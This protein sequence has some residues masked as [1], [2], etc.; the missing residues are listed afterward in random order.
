VSR[1]D[2]A[3]LSVYVS[4]SPSGYR[5]DIDGLRAI[6]VVAVLAFHAS[7]A[8]FPGGFAGVDVFFVISGF[9]ITGVLASDLSQGRFTLREF[10]LRRARRIFPA[11]TLVL[12]VTLLGAWMMLLPDEWL[13]FG[14]HLLAGAAFA[15]NLALA[16][17]GSYFDWSA[18]LKPLLHLWSLG[19]EEQF[20]LV[21][22]LFLAVLWKLRA[23]WRIAGVAFVLMLSLGLNV[24][25]IERY[26]TLAFYLP[27]TRVWELACGSLLALVSRTWTVRGRWIPEVLSWSGLALL[28]AAFLVLVD[29]S[30]APG[31]WNLLPVGG[32]TLLIAAGRESS[33]SRFVL[34]S[35][36]FVFVGLISYPLYLWHWPLLSFT[37]IIGLTSGRTTLLCL[38]LA[39]LFSWLTYRYVER[40]IRGATRFGGRVA[41]VCA[42][43]ALLG[44][45]GLLIMRGLLP[46]RLSGSHLAPVRQA[47]A[48]WQYPY[49]ENFG[50]TTNFTASLVNEGKGR[51]VVFIGDSHLE[52]YWPRLE[53]LSR[54]ANAPEMVFATNGGCPPLP[55]LAVPRGE[56][57]SRFLDFALREAHQPD[58]RTVVFGAHWAAYLSLAEMRE[59]IRRMADEIVRLRREGKQVFVV[60]ASP[61]S[62]RLEPRSMVS[63]WSGLVRH[64]SLPLADFLAT[65]GPINESIRVAVQRAGA[66]VIDPLPVL[67]PR[68]EC[69]VV[70]SSG[71]PIYR[72]SSHLRP[73]FVR[74][75]AS[76]IDVVLAE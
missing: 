9:L 71:K 44:V 24:L 8:L 52:H 53:V 16:R 17:E 22:P 60:L 46:G 40:P 12:A 76:Y 51:T 5:A 63:R 48:D 38:L 45:A 43:L 34:S 61:S 66:R 36:P 74:E 13:H 70:T 49:G 4:A 72:D 62:S 35:R 7:P 75:N 28:G 20:Y 69:I 33:L 2:N 68:G 27:V 64:G 18:H 25:Y 29:R 65:A 21:W 30:S 67:C 19:V 1:P 47:M 41:V 58:V 37:H 31:W 10:Y 26:P 56:I 55:G 54:R 59:P 23:R 32:T 39:F 15:S 42:A 73:F 14:K 11:L 6:A 57:C 50:R 3:T